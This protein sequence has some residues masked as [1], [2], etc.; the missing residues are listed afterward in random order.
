M[1]SIQ[2][3]WTNFRNEFPTQ[4]KMFSK[5]LISCLTDEVSFGGDGITDLHSQHQQAEEN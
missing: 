4:G 5:Q 2:N 3:A 1:G